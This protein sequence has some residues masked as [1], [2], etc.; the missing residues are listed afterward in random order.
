MIFNERQN[1]AHQLP[2][3][4]LLSLLSSLKLIVLGDVT[5]KG[6]HHDH[7][8]HARQEEHDHQAIDD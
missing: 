6:A 4:L 7:G 5:M 2:A 1:C 3:S 8:N